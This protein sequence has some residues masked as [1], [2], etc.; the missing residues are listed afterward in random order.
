ME[1]KSMD[2]QSKA[3]SS[4]FL[5]QR[6][7]LQT[8]IRSMLRD[9]DAAEDVFQEVW[10]QFADAQQK[11]TEIQNLA[12]WSRGVARN[13]ILKHWRRQRTSKVIADSEMLELVEE[14]F[15]EQDDREAYWESRR[16]AL[17]ACMKKLPEKSRQILDLRY[18][19]DQ[20]VAAVAEGLGK[21]TASV[22]MMLSRIR[23]SLSACAERALKGALA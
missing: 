8:F 12:K 14:A 6:H 11:G 18:E 13:L 7:A 10:L 21:T 23:K 9:D 22:M 16:K 5:K 2:A 3:L 4:L 15:D 19:G 20:P 17:K 1:R